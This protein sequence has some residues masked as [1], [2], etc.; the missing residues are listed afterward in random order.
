MSKQGDD[1]QPVAE[2]TGDVAANPYQSPEAVEDL[3]IIVP[4]QGNTDLVW[5][6][7]AAAAVLAII[8]GVAYWWF[9]SFN[10]LGLTL[11]S[12][13]VP[14][15]LLSVLVVAL[16]FLLLRILDHKRANADRNA[17]LVAG[18]VLG[19][20]VGVA[21]TCLSLLRFQREYTSWGLTLMVT[22]IACAIVATVQVRRSNN[23]PVPRRPVPETGNQTHASIF[24]FSAG[25]LFFGALSGFALQPNMSW[26]SAVIST[27][28][29]A[30]LLCLL[31]TACYGLANLPY[32]RTHI[33]TVPARIAAA[34]TF[35]G[36]V[37][38]IGALLQFYDAPMGT[39]RL[40]MLI[41]ATLA[42]VLVDRVCSAIGRRK[43]PVS[44]RP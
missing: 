30:A 34:F 13:L 24:W 43:S 25:C 18:V 12:S 10:T 4:Q 5:M 36:S 29:T 17:Q 9:F 11:V 28:L 41:P 20:V 6:A 42:A 37:A 2:S 26:Q 19:L 32:R 44:R 16:Y 40:L 21:Y 3:E 35:S 15:A 33:V 22:L 23:S 39:I 1:T 14:T 7:G 8:N 27:V 31:G 38:L